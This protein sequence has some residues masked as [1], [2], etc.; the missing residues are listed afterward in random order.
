MA[1]RMLD[2]QVAASR[3]SRGD[4]IEYLLREKAGVLNENSTLA[5]TETTTAETESYATEPTSPVQPSPTQQPEKTEEPVAVYANP[6]QSVPSSS[7]NN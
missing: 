4:Y 3:M 5:E 1:H 7:W 2:E 6:G